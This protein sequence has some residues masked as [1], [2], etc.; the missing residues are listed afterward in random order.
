MTITRMCALVL[1]LLLALG[2]C[3]RRDPY[4]DAYLEIVK[5]HVDAINAVIVG[6]IAG[7]GGDTGRELNQVLQAAIKKYAPA[8]T[9]ISTRFETSK[10][11]SGASR[12]RP[13]S[14]LGQRS[15]RAGAAGGWRV[16]PRGLVMLTG[17][18]RSTR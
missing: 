1:G 12:P 16:A 8:T 2:G 4:T 15:G 11:P 3:R 6:R 17:G 7:D 13:V 10:P 18:S 9:T 14:A 5:A